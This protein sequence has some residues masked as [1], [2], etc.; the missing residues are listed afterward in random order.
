MTAC[1]TCSISG[2]L[3]T[4]SEQ[5]P[6]SLHDNAVASAKEQRQQQDPQRTQPAF[7][8][9]LVAE[10]LEPHALPVSCCFCGFTTQERFCPSVSCWIWQT[11]FPF[12]TAKC[13][14]RLRESCKNKRN[15]ILSGLTLM[16]SMQ[17]AVRGSSG[18]PS[19]LSRDPTLSA[20]TSA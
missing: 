2:L 1:A 16:P 14:S 18:G 3:L 12:V 5:H 7:A 10:T 20:L 15:V 13:S 11:P 8:G 4:A 6:E 9:L 19:S 17:H